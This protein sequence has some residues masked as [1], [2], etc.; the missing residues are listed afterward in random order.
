MLLAK[1]L[2]CTSDTWQNTLRNWF[3][4]VLMVI[5]MQFSPPLCVRLLSRRLSARCPRPDG[6]ENRWARAFRAGRASPPRFGSLDGVIAQRRAAALVP[7]LLSPAA[8]AVPGF[9]EGLSRP[10]ARAFAAY[11]QSASW[12]IRRVLLVS[13]LW[14]CAWSPMA[15][16]AKMMLG[17]VAEA[18]G[19][20]DGFWPAGGL[21]SGFICVTRFQTQ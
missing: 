14:F 11:C 4:R 20:L 13:L 19:Q 5:S 12:E 6:R 3:L 17:M 10:P 9:G 2:F 16:G 7:A 8:G 15:R 1:Q 21:C 18:A